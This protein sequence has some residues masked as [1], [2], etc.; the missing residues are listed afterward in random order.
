[1]ITCVTQHSEVLWVQQLDHAMCITD[2]DII[3]WKLCTRFRNLLLK[4]LNLKLSIHSFLY[5]SILCLYN[6]NWPLTFLKM[7]FCAYNSE[8]LQSEIF[9]SKIDIWCFKNT[10]LSVNSVTLRMFCPVNLLPIKDH[11]FLTNAFLIH[12][13]IRRT[14][15]IPICYCAIFALVWM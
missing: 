6:N 14:I 10:L 9:L 13:S 2:P 12:S 1:M 3:H 15:K 8:E 11:G 4:L 5:G 7:K